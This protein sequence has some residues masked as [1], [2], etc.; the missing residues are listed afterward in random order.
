[1]I[2]TA[3]GSLRYTVA[4]LGVDHSLLFTFIDYL[5]F[6][7]TQFSRLCKKLQILFDIFK[8]KILKGNPVSTV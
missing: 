4:A 5:N 6:V 3:L 7:I 2:S 8:I 1:M